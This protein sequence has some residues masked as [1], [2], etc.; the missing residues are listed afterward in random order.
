MLFTFAADD[1]E[2]KSIDILSIPD[3]LDFIS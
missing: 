2:L 3:C 1:G